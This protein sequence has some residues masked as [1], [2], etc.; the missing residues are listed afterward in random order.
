MKAAIIA[1]FALFAMDISA[2]CRQTSLAEQHVD[3]LVAS[4]RVMTI[5]GEA[6]Y[7]KE[8]EDSVK[9]LIERFYYDQFHHIQDPDAPYFLFM[10][11]DAQLAMGIGGCVRM[12]GYF[13]WGGAIPA[14]GFAPYLIPMEPDPA[15]RKHLG[16]TPAGTALYFRVIGMNKALGNYQ[17]YIE[18]DFNG[19]QSRDFH[20]KKAYAMI[21][22][23]TIGYA[24]STF[25]DPVATPPTVDAQGP[26]NK[27]A[28]TSVLVRWM[29]TFRKHWSVGVS[30]ETPSANVEVDGTTTD[31]VDDW[32]P[33]WAVSVQYQWSRAEHV[34][35]S[36]IVRTLSYRDLVVGKNH[37]VTGWG[38]QLSSVSHPLPQLTVYANASCGH[39]YASLGGDLQ[40]GNHDL[41]ADESCPGRMYAPLSY[42]WN[43]SLQ[44]NFTSSLFVSVTASQTRYCPVGDVKADEY[45]LGR[46]YA[47]NIFW[48]L[49]PRIQFG[50]EIDLGCRHD[51]GGAHRWARRVG[52]MTQFSF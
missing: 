44:Y 40:I 3:S 23:V 11:K 21:N 41:V 29:P 18:A 27:I 50:A 12:R 22:D 31:K 33:D 32:M 34:R 24:N 20:L 49:T 42:G 52:M 45:R 47:A 5:D 17:L 30:V 48:N 14:S 36:G 51:F 19:Y 6:T 37:S 4:R 25:S 39:G 9:A 43:V 35:L 28:P 8:H 7:S 13:D 2:E 26:N 10:S 1:V 16:T 15:K 38:V 46:F